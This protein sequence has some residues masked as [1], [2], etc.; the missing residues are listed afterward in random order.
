M[1]GKYAVAVAGILGAVALGV[2]NLYFEGPDS[3]VAAAIVGVI[4]LIVGYAFGYV[5]RPAE[6]E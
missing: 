5:K 6:A 1:E 2:A 3:T 4:G